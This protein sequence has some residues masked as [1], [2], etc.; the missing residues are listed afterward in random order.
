MAQ[1]K[2]KVVDF[3]GK[4]GE[5][6]VYKRNGKTFVRQRHISQPRRLSRKQLAQRE[7]LAHNNA[8]WRVLRD[9]EALY[10]E[11]GAGPYYRFMSVNRYAPIVYLTKHQLSSGDTL[12][13]PETV[14][15]DGP[16]SPMAYQLG[17]HN[18]T[19]ALLTDLPLEEVKKGKLLLYALTQNVK[20][21]FDGREQARM[22]LEVKEVDLSKTEVSDGCLVLTD[23][24]FADPMKGFALVR[25]VDGHAS[26]QRVVTNCTYYKRF[27]TEE[28]L[29]AAAK[30]YRGLTK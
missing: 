25:V 13:L 4:L 14:M 29:L 5:V 30:S 15:S 10:F 21:F 18:G 7:Q 9:A 12:L 8:V 17:E 20:Q 24:S 11:G 23:K 6:T 28:A 16:L 3:E 22:K 2:N 26:H 19:P 27:T 1:L